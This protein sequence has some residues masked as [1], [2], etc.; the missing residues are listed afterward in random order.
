MKQIENEILNDLEEKRCRLFEIR[1]PK[2]RK[3]NRWYVQLTD[4]IDEL[5][6]KH[7]KKSLRKHAK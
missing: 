6:R 4:T 3:L 7:V 5:K 1:T 2:T